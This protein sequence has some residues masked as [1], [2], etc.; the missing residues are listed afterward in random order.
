M[1]TFGFRCDINAQVET[2]H[3]YAQLGK[4]IQQARIHAG[5]KQE[6]LALSLNLSRTSVTNIERG[7]QHLQVHHLVRV[8]DILGV[9][10]DTL[11][12]GLLT[13]FEEGTLPVA[14]EKLEAP[15][16]EWVRRITSRS[17]PGTEDDDGGSV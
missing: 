12:N 6:Q 7:R 13:P 8:A 16:R 14:A 4:R 2:D 3:F 15:E 17:R 5:L 10:V 1:L 11:L 9:S